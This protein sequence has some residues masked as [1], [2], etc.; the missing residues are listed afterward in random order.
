MSVHKVTPVGGLRFVAHPSVALD[1]LAAPWIHLNET[2]GGMRELGCRA[3]IVRFGMLEFLL[4]RRGVPVVGPLLGAISE[5]LLPWAV[6]L[7]CLTS[8]HIPYIRHYYDLSPSYFLLALVRRRFVVEV[9]ATLREE[10]HL[11]SRGPSFLLRA[12]RRCET[13]ALR[14]AD[15]VITVSDVM[16][17]RLLESGLDATRV[18]A[19]HNG[20]N[21]EPDGERV[22]EEQTSGILFVGNFKRWQRVELLIDALAGLEDDTR[23]LLAGRGATASLRARTDELGV[24]DRVEFLG[25]VDHASVQNLM[26]RSRV[27]VL[28]H[29]ND[30]GSPMKLFEYL[31][32]GRPVV[33]PDIP[34]LREV[35]THEEHALLF[36]PGDHQELTGCLRRLLGDRELCLSLGSRGRALVCSEYT[37]RKNAER[38]VAAVS[39]RIGL[40]CRGG[41]GAP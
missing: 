7:S 4:R 2:A 6:F 19:V 18:F 27:L 23:M 5:L 17:A 13:A 21:C 15:V 28:A 36:R 8:D 30:Y 26:R 37:W 35:V 11:L 9:N 12:A 25:P 24:A 14:R 38:T 40:R 41:G 16:R 29:S 10:T 33:L 20:C 34:V 32:S 39:S 1:E 3:V 31:A 22:P